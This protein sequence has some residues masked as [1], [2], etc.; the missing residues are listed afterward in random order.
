MTMDR[1]I[2]RSRE[3]E[4]KTAKAHGGRR[5]AGSGATWSRKGDVRTAHT[6]IENKRTDARQITLKANDLEKIWREAI[7][8]GRIPVIEIEVGGKSYVVLTQSDYL[9]HMGNL[10]EEEDAQSGGPDLAGRQA[11]LAQRG[12]V[13]RG[14]P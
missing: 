13:S 7:A 14:R 4:H 1:R 10:D 11:K 3:Q 6:L 5:N 9:E 12:S 8:E 2:K